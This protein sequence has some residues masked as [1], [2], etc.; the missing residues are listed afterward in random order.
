MSD[1]AIR[2]IHVYIEYSSIIIMS[3]AIQLPKLIGATRPG[4]AFINSVF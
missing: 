4:R 1:N 3:H 2:P